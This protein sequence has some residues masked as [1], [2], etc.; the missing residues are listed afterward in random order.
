[1][2]RNAEA[3]RRLMT[4]ANA[5]AERTAYRTRNGTR[6]LAALLRRK[7]KWCL[8]LRFSLRPPDPEPSLG[9]GAAFSDLFQERTGQSGNPCPHPE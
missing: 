4:P 6:K 7:T 1:V 5:A 2:F 3:S 8:M 9:D